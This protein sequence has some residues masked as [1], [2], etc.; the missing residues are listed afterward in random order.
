MK[1]K[2]LNKA[3]NAINLPPLLRS[4]SVTDKIPVYFGFKDKEPPTVSYEY[5]STVASRLFNFLIHKL[6]SVTNP[7]FVMNMAMLSLEI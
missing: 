2:F 7:S 6:A 5:T 1:I 4:T 3:V